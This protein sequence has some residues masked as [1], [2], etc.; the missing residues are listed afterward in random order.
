M[1]HKRTVVKAAAALAL[2]LLACTVA[3]RSVYTL[4][5]PRVSVTSVRTDTLHSTAVYSGQFS[6]ESAGADVLAGGSWTV[7]EQ[8]A[9]DG[10]TVQAGDALLRIDITDYQ[11]QLRQME[12]NIQQQRN[13]INATNWT[14]GDRLV[15]NQQLE[16]LEMQ[17]AQLKASFPASGLVTAT[18]AGTVSGLAGPGP[19]ARG[20]VLAHIAAPG[21][22]GQVAFQAPAAALEDLFGSSARIRCAYT[23]LAGQGALR[24]EKRETALEP[25]RV[26]A[27]AG[28]FYTVYADLAEAPEEP[29]E[30]GTPATVTVESQSGAVNCVP[31]SAIFY[32]EG[33]TCVYQVL[34]RDTIWGAEDYV[35]AVE[36]E[37]TDSDAVNAAVPDL[38]AGVLDARY[39]CYP[40]RSLVDGEAVRVGE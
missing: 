10:D 23:A 37:V 15:L 3:A 30:P 1:A 9:A 17:Y 35:Q 36:V 2:A 20:S 25:V 11:I 16:A 19:V 14:G 26:E 13:T 18:A 8:L 4:L 34:Q 40:S 33:K 29:V 27:A 32:S 28:G 7:T 22:A 31:L 21:A 6:G 39:A 5:L 24:A 12:A 38:S